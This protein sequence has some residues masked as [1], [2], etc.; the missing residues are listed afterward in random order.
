MK[1]YPKAYSDDGKHLVMIPDGDV[2]MCEDGLPSHY[3]WIGYKGDSYPERSFTISKIA[4]LKKIRD[5]IN[6]ILDVAESSGKNG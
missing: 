3:L 6:L 5:N 1:K 2:E 4:E